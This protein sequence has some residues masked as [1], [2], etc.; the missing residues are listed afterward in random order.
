MDYYSKYLKYKNK[1]LH[2]KSTFDNNNI[3]SGGDKPFITN[4][5]DNINLIRD[6]KMKKYLNPNYGLI[7]SESGFV[8]NNYYLNKSNFLNVNDTQLYID[9]TVL[10][11]NKTKPCIN[12]ICKEDAGNIKP[13]NDIMKLKPLDFGRYIAIKYINKNINYIT[14]NQNQNQIFINRIHTDFRKNDSSGE[15]SEQHITTLREWINKFNKYIRVVGNDDKFY[16]HMILYCLWWNADNYQGI[17]EYYQGINEVFELL[18]TYLNQA[19]QYHQINIDL[20]NPPGNSFEKKLIEITN[21]DFKIYTQQ[22]SKDFCATSTT[23]P[24]CGETTARNLINLICFNDNALNIQLLSKFKPIP[25][26]LDYYRHQII[27]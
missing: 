18:N 21:K 4:N 7:L 22:Q 10:H 16:F 27:K 6:E 25:Q 3:Q 9:G 14:T 2:L 5:D 1:Y 8:I 15:I 24:D 23:Y 19:N 20:T 17:L 13:T 11:I 26:L 12:K